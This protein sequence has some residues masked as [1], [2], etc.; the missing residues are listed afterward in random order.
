M[1]ESAVKQLTDD[2]IAMG[3][4]LGLWAYYGVILFVVTPICRGW[5]MSV[6]WRWFVVPA[7]ELPSISITQAI[8]LILVLNYIVSWPAAKK[9][10]DERKALGILSLCLLRFFYAA[11]LPLLSVGL[12]WIVLQFV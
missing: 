8:G 11:V 6:L 5:A 12:G 10:E 7:F 4:G 1:L 2:V 9:S 3:Y